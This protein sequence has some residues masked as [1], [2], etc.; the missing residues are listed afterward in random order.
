MILRIIQTEHDIKNY[1][2]RGIILDIMRKLNL[3]ELFYYTFK[4][5]IVKCKAGPGGHVPGQFQEKYR[6]VALV[7]DV[8]FFEKTFRNLMTALLTKGAN[9][10]KLRNYF[11]GSYIFP[12]LHSFFFLLIWF[13]LYFF[14][15]NRS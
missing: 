13:V 15:E 8:S 3:I 7:N 5:V 1:P 10:H 9:N 14:F 11:L 6:K 2:D 4:I 12:Q